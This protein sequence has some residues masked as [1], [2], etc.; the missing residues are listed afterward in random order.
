MNHHYLTFRALAAEWNSRLSGAEVSEIFTQAKNELLITF[1]LAGGDGSATLHC[2][3]DPQMTYAVVRPMAQRARR[4]SVDLFDQLRGEILL[5]CSLH[6][7]DRTLDFAFGGGSHLFFRLYGT[8]EN[9]II[10]ADSRGVILNA[11]KNGRDLRGTTFEPPPDRSDVIT[12]PAL[13]RA[14]LMKSAS[15]PV[16]QAI[17]HAVPILGPVYIAEIL[18]TCGSNSAAFAQELDDAAVSGIRLAVVDLFVKAVHPEA[19]IC[20]MGGDNYFTS[21]VPLKQDGVEGIQSFAGMNEAVAASLSAGFRRHAAGEH[22]DSVLE[23]IRESRAAIAKSMGRTAER[24]APDPAEIEQLGRLLLMNIGEVRK[25]MTSIEVADELRGGRVVKITL[26]PALPPTANAEK[27]FEKA[28]NIKRDR[29]ESE[30]RGREFRAKDAVLTLLE[31]SRAACESDESRKEWMETHEDE[32]EELGL[33]GG[34]DE[35]EKPPFRLFV[36]A[37][38]YEVWVGKNSANNDLLTF[39]YSKP[40]D[41]WM[42]ARGSSG[43]H[44]VVKVREK[45]K[46]IP[47]EALQQAAGIAAYYSK[48]R[49]AK[50]VPVAYCERKYVRKPKGAP[51]GTVTLEREE[52]LFVNPRLP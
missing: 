27:Y 14:A 25:G 36:V 37:G 34:A 30:K 12:D 19:S 8:A 15:K 20:R 42:H 10:L 46:V 17:R 47:K 9:N 1:R 28:K 40:N 13:F 4:N 11:F 29:E 5:S 6:P 51:P 16:G 49:N 32:L 18:H 39:R 35:K 45:G 33:G 22:P 41:I 31:S 23:R 50:H 24:H 48:M 38:G 52:I 7:S 21:V 26:D 44:T 43:S 3:V 2:S